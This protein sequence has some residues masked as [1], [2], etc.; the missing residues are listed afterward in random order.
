MPPAPRHTRRWFR[1]SLG[2][3]LVLRRDK[4]NVIRTGMPVILVGGITSFAFATPQPSDRLCYGS[5]EYVVY[6]VP[7]LGLWY[8]GEG[9]PPDGKCRPPIFD[10]SSGN[11]SGYA[12]TWEIRHKQ[13]RLRSIEGRIKGQDRKNESILPSRKFPVVATWFTGRI[14]LPVGDFDDERQQYESVI[15]FEIEKGEVESTTF[16][17]SAKI[18]NT[19]NG[20]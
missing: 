17:P 15:V 18:T 10:S 12:A 16:V 13:L 3:R 2:T 1:F 14:H 19:W 7:M 5:N 9:K 6:Q 8:Y 20:L 11:W 4:M